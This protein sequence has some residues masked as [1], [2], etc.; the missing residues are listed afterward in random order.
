[1]DYV[2]FVIFFLFG[3][4]FGRLVIRRLG[5]GPTG[6]L[7]MDDW[8][9]DGLPSE[10][11]VDLKTAMSDLSQ[12]IWC[13]GWMSDSE[14]LFWEDLV[15]DRETTPLLRHADRLRLQALSRCAGGWLRWNS[16][17][18]KFSPDTDNPKFE[19]QP[20]VLFVPADEWSDLY[21]K[22]LSEMVERGM[23]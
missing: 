3:I 22:W 9:E 17:K 19:I 2:R 16:R 5:W 10:C 18:L 14:Y 6:A 11:V 21:G 23:R 15:G 7:Q 1:M 20:E 12:D 4:W 13:A 8:F